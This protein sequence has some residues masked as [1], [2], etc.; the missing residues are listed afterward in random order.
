MLTAVTILGRADPN[1]FRL[2]VNREVI[3]GYCCCWAMIGVMGIQDSLWM[4]DTVVLFLDL[5]PYWELGAERKDG[6]LRR[7]A[8]W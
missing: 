1:L 3:V 8:L 6:L 4:L 7:L 2:V 5:I